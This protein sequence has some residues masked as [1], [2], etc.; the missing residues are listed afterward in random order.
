MQLRTIAIG[1]VV[2][3]VSAIVTTALATAFVVLI[4]KDHFARPVGSGAARI[5]SRAVRIAYVVGKN[6]LGFVLL[7]AGAVMALPGV[8]GQG[9][10][11]MLIGLV[12][13]DVPG[14][15]R[16]ELRLVSRRAVRR[17]LDRVRARFGRP[18]LQLDATRPLGP[19]D[20]VLAP[21]DPSPN[22]AARPSSSERS[23]TSDE[24]A[25]PGDP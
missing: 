2:F 10:L 15:R 18:P 19:A 23:A 6:V 16:F 17:A 4:P 3:V 24:G 5:R 25:P 11:T 21:E 14:K 13:L 8:P 22:A 9:I 12:L 1:A 7:C 20:P